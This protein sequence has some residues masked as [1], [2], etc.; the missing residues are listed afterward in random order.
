[1]EVY[2]RPTFKGNIS[3][4]LRVSEEVEEEPDTKND[5]EV[6]IEAL[7]GLGVGN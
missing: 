2:P 4:F 6:A 5:E 3:R 1:M 7:L